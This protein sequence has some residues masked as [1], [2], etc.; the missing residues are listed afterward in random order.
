MSNQLAPLSHYTLT[1]TGGAQR[2]STVMNQADGV[3][4]RKISFQAGAANA[5]AVYIGGPG[6][7]DTDYGVRIPIPVSTVPEAPYLYEDPDEGL[8]LGNIYVFG[9]NTEKLHL[10]IQ[11]Y[12]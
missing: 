5:A 2:V 12:V 8:T 4:I 9:A 1:L 11:P 10:L 7:S 6:V 3:R